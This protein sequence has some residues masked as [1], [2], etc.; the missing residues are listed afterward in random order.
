M[1]QISLKTALTL[2]DRKNNIKCFSFNIFTGLE[3]LPSEKIVNLRMHLDGP[4]LCFTLLDLD[5]LKI[6]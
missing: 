3:L 1:K 2:V 6:K 5:K 4:F